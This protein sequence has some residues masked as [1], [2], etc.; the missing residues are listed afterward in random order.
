MNESREVSM[1]FRH[2]K[3]VSSSFHNGKHLSSLPRNVGNGLMFGNAGQ[4][5]EVRGEE[6]RM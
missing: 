4:V 1:V 3:Q 6:V 2:K 5:D